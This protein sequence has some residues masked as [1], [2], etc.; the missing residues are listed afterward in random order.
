MAGAVPLAGY[1]VLH[2]TTQ[3]SALAGAEGYAALTRAVDRIP[4][5]LGLEVLVIYLPLSFH[6]IAGLARP[7]LRSAGETGPWW[8]PLQLVS[9]LVLLAFLGFHFW[10]FRWRL[11][12]GELARADF[13][14]ELCASLS[15]TA[16]GGVP[17]VALAYLAGVA[18]AAFHAARGLARAASTWRF[19]RGRQRLLARACAGFGFGLFVLGALI[20]IDLATGS[21]LIHLPG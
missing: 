21:V 6:V 3:A 1:L 8:R 2:L 16:R 4:G 7:P 17:L 20:V 13:Y 14:P 10:Q 12:T 18:A 5:L 11:W 9:G 15:S 19:A